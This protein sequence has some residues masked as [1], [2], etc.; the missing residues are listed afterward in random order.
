MPNFCTRERLCL[1]YTPSLYRCDVKKKLEPFPPSQCL[2]RLDQSPLVYFRCGHDARNKIGTRLINSKNAPFKGLL[3][4]MG[5]KLSC[6]CGPLKIKGYRFDANA[7]PWAQHSQQANNSQLP[8]RGGSRRA[9]GQL[10]RLWAEVFHVTTSS[11]GSVKWSQVSEDLVPVNI[12]CVPNAGG[13]VAPVPTTQ[14]GLN[15]G[16]N[17]GNNNNNGQ[18]DS[19]NNQ[20]PAAQQ[21]VVF[22]VTAYNSQVEKILDVR[23]IQ[24]GTRI[25]QASECFVYWKDPATN[26]TWGLNFTSPIDAKQ[27]REC[28]CRE[29]KRPV[30]N[31]GIWAR[32]DETWCLDD[33]VLQAGTY[34]VDC[35]HGEA[36]DAARVHARL[37]RNNI[38]PSSRSTPASPSRSRGGGLSG[39][40]E[41][42]CT[43]MT[44]AEHF[45]GRRSN[46]PRLR[47]VTPCGGTSG[48]SSQH[49]HAHGSSHDARRKRETQSTPSSPTRGRSASRT[50]QCTC[51]TPEQ[52]AVLQGYQHA[53]SSRGSQTL[54]R[55]LSGSRD[56]VSDAS[57][58]SGAH[59]SSSVYDNVKRNESR[60]GNQG[61]DGYGSVREA[62]RTRLSQRDI[63][64]S[65]DQS[66]RG[67]PRQ[68]G[69][70]DSTRSRRGRNELLNSKSVDYHDTRQTGAHRASL[71]MGGTAHQSRAD[72]VRRMRSKSTDQLHHPDDRNC[73]R[74]DSGTLKRMLKPV[75]TAP[76]SPVTSPEGGRRGKAAGM[77]SM[78][79]KTNNG[80]L[81]PHSSQRYDSDRDGGFMSE[82]EPPGN[83][84]RRN[85]SQGQSVDMAS[86][87]YRDIGRTSTGNNQFYK[88]RGGSGA[89]R[90]PNNRS[91]Y[92]DFNEQGVPRDRTGSPP[93][94]SGGIFDSHCFAT[95]PSSSNGNSD[96]EG[97]DTTRASP[98][99]QL[100]MDYEEHL[101]NTLEK[102]MDAE[103]YSL[104][105][106]EALLTRSMENLVGL[107]FDS[108]GEVIVPQKFKD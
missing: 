80:Y 1:R 32:F 106:F 68:P 51:M 31:P 89:L 91:L 54:P 81:P 67:T 87:T 43:C 83:R 5:N 46:D 82:P 104:H 7:E 47:A 95:T 76:E 85:I 94:D 59:S 108:S 9:E 58:V 29:R 38:K 60:M 37:N 98:T 15:G 35:E 16:G 77:G 23:L 27:F 42:R 73:S 22:H 84:V 56:D 18:Q 86:N 88:T 103:S 79:G 17:G 63:S 41:P 61:G 62:D 99:S 11:S 100:L 25:G 19:Q 55:N 10:L 101:R 2:N 92:L 36:E 39:G 40:E 78:G 66:G 14:A 50:A 74:F 21:Q 105:T 102:G 64:R 90:N 34:Y 24:P 97:N 96:L 72:H 28:C 48:G 93:S 53:S 33:V 13:G 8:S 3:K 12:T 52:F 75:Q 107:D 71:S 20:T 44:S 4:K 57:R 69:G 65:A 26:D 6:S 49:H 30:M 70:F 45:S